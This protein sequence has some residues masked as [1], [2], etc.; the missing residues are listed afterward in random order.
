MK[1]LENIC[2][3]FGFPLSDFWDTYMDD[4][5]WMKENIASIKYP[6]IIK[7][8]DTGVYSPKEYTSNEFCQIGF[9]KDELSKLLKKL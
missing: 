1:Y 5:T 8:D 7:H 3:K 2:S 9:N 6:I 4:T